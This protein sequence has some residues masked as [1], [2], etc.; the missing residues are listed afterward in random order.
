MSFL[1]KT[2]LGDGVVH[3]PE[4]G[5]DKDKPS[6][7]EEQ[8][9]QR[10]PTR[11][12]ILRI[13]SCTVAQ[14]R[15]DALKELLSCTDLPYVMAAKEVSYLCNV[16]RN[17]PD[18]EEIVESSLAVLSSITDLAGYPSAPSTYSVSEK[19]KRRIRDSFLHELISEVPLF[20]NH[21]NKGSFWSRFHS[22]QMLQRLEEYDSSAVHKLLL[23][24]H[25]IGVLVDILND[26][27]HGGALR[28]EGLVLFTAITATDTEL[29]T[30][31]AFDNAFETLFSVVKEEGG[32][33]GGVIVSDC[34]TIVHNMLR[35]NKATQKLFRE[36]GCARLLCSLIEAVPE[37]VKSSMKNIVSQKKQGG[38]NDGDD[39]ETGFTPLS[40][41]QSVVVLMAVS[42]LSCILREAEAHQEGPT[43]QDALLQS[44]VLDPL[45]SLALVGAA[46]DDAARVEAMRTLAVLLNGRR[47]GIEKFLQLQVVTL[48]RGEAPMQVEEWTALRALLHVLLRVEDRVM[49]TAAAQTIFAL[50]SVPACEGR[51]GSILLKGFASPSSSPSSSTTKASVTMVAS[52]NILTPDCGSAIS[53][54]IFGSSGSTE[55]SGKYYAALLLERLLC[56]PSAVEEID[57]S[58]QRESTTL[59]IPK[60]STSPV[61]NNV[62]IAYVQYVTKCFRGQGEMDLNT[63]SACFRALLRWIMSSRK[64]ALLFLSNIGCYKT[65]LQRSGQD[66]GPVHVRF[67][68]AVLC[69]ALCVTVTKEKLSVTSDV[70]VPEEQMKT[71]KRSKSEMDDGTSSVSS[72]SSS[73]LGRRQLLELFLNYLGGPAIFDSLLFDVKASSPVWSDPPKN[74]FLKPTPVL[75][76][77]NIK[78]M[79]LGIIKDFNG[80]CPSRG[81]IHELQVSASLD[82]GAIPSAHASTSDE[83]LYSN[84]PLDISSNSAAVNT[85]LAGQTLPGVALNPPESHD[86]GD[87]LS[88]SNLKSLRES[89]PEKGEGGEAVATAALREMYETQIATLTQRNTELER[90][91]H[92]LQDQVKFDAEQREAAADRETRQLEEMESLREHIRVLEEALGAE[93]EQRRVLAQSL[94]MLE[95]QL[96]GARGAPGGGNGN[97]EALALLEEVRRVTDE[98]DE[99]LVLAGEL[100][101]SPA[102]RPSD[103]P[104]PSP[105]LP[106]PS[107]APSVAPEAMKEERGGYFHHQLPIGG[108]EST[109]SRAQIFDSPEPNNPT[110]RF[111]TS[112]AQQGLQYQYQ[113]HH[114]LQI[115]G[116][117]PFERV[118]TNGHDR[119][120]IMSNIP[121]D[122][123]RNPFA[124]ISSDDFMNNG[125]GEVPTEE[126]EKQPVFSTPNQ[127]RSVPLHYNPFANMSD[128]G[129]DDDPGDLR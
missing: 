45:A 83:V 31:L 86:G 109:P 78:T 56:I 5:V 36:M 16:L 79:I 38:T 48:L 99:L 42:I 75:Y 95:A 35:N 89:T 28:N 10:V 74:A 13:Q 49:Q 117:A 71:E 114:R 65:L 25:G 62:F 18:D 7:Q 120:G 6:T 43:A 107:A 125:D 44:G 128:P 57:L 81:R 27:S 85:F 24:S 98:R 90:E 46:V 32:L 119:G 20:L 59:P 1:I 51:V 112:S 58:E 102:L 84:K 73:A 92:L 94:N 103:L 70:A 21:V 104:S 93:E 82:E 60:Q 3:P 67:W 126:V 23:S 87:T 8:G 26:N 110:G 14:D 88:Q 108:S 41:V 121:V 66:N 96:Q 127:R 34:L 47:V 129:P 69:A 2:L 15:R 80:I 122:G 123:G 97:G 37:H 124:N 12:L 77:E 11:T 101:E 30:L 118:E 50:L 115:P 19:E 105:P 76:D 33:D 61:T 72:S 91:L 64:A 100:A 52:K 55:C 106:P 39:A 63:L 22:V 53:S 9:K 17:F 116:G 111:S 113:H 54:A 68:A 40:N 4:D 29:Q